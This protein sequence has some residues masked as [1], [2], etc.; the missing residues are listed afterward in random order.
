M[1]LLISSTVFQLTLTLRIGTKTGHQRKF[2]KKPNN[3]YGFA[4][5]LEYDGET[6][7]HF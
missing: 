4:I 1:F 3:C 7:H 2:K 5:K 6:I